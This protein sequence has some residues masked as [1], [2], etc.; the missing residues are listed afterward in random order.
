LTSCFITDDILGAIAGPFDLAT[1]AQ[2]AVFQAGSGPIVGETINIAT[3]TCLDQLE[4]EVDDTDTVTVDSIAPSILVEKLCLP[5]EIQPAPGTIMWWITVTNN[6]DATLWD[7]SIMDADLGLDESGIH[8]DAGEVLEFHFEQTDL[9]AG[10]Y[11]N[12]SSAS[13]VDQLENQYFSEDTATCEVEEVGNAGCTPGFWK[14][15]ADKHDYAAWPAGTFE[16]VL[17]SEVF[18]EVITID[19]KKKQTITDPTLEEALAASGGGINALARHGTAAYLNSIDAEVQYPFS[20]AGVIAIVQ[21]EIAN[22]T[23]DHSE[24]ATANELG[25]TQNQKG[26]PTEQE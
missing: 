19:A 20:E 14:N 5:E 7:V 21:E 24:L 17:F 6:G 26:E 1:G 10:V 18:G 23:Y 4:S 12:T 9:E 11:V 13:G 2:S 22:E 3:V 15:N 8:L 25:C 16:D